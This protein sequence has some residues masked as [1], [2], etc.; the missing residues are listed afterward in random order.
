VKRW[1][2]TDDVLQNA[3]VRLYRA[4]GQVKP[5]SA[6]DFF[7]L[8]ALNIRRELLDLA[9]HYYGPR[10]PGTKHAS[11]GPK[12]GAEDDPPAAYEAPA[13]GGE[14]DGL[15][16]WTEF[17]RQIDLLPDED[18]ETF[19][20]LWYQGLSQAEAAALLNVSERTI[21]RRWQSA[22]LKLHQALGGALP[23]L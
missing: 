5:A 19:D 9:K 8:A 12:S 18:R 22:R 1:E 3:A 10:G 2:Q 14:P 4:L 7:R 21:K 16:A 23:E 17:H 6:A 11:V 20:L 13:P 15:D